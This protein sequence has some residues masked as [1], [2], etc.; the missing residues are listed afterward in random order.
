MTQKLLVTGASGQLG[1]A[2]V[3]HLIDTLHI[4][5]GRIV[6]ATR[7]PE[8][9]DAFWNRGVSVRYADFEDVGSLGCAFNGIDRM[10]LISTDALDRR[11]R[12]FAQQLAAVTAA[13][14]AG[15]NHVVYTSM[16]NADR[17]TVIVAPDHAA[18]EAALAS[19]VIPGWTVLR[20]HWYF[21]NL[22]LTLPAILRNGGQWFH[23]AGAGKLANISRDDLALAAAAALADTSGGKRMFTL[24]GSEALTTDEQAN[25]IGDTLG[26]RISPVFLPEEALVGRMVKS[27]LP[28]GLARIFASFDANTAAGFVGTV[29]K[30]FHHLTGKHPKS[31][32]AWLADHR[33]G[34]TKLLS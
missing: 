4:E 31:F 1:Q 6:A 32:S 21:D 30:D 9:L 15:V 8:A 20:N 7:T 10:L 2:V 34:L 5:P 23:A 26:T 19:T 17:A 29:T 18:T 22:Y 24:S 16:P 13:E 28:Q 14:A 11:G 27:G 3:R 12:R 33:G 25:L